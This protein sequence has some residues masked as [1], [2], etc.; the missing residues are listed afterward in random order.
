MHFIYPNPKSCYA[1]AGS[2]SREYIHVRRDGYIGAG[3]E[4]PV[5]CKLASIL[6]PFDSEECKEEDERGCDHK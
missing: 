4:S 5:G 3:W 2:M 6:A 1:D